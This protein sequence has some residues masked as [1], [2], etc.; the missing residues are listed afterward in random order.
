MNKKITVDVLMLI[1][2]IVEFLSLPIIIHEIVGIGLIFL[3]ALHINY[4][5]RYFKA[6]RKGKYNLKRTFELIVN[7]GLLVS[8]LI[9]IISGIF[10]SQKSFKGKKIGKY[11]IKHIHKSSSIISLVF[12][13]LHLGVT[14]KKLL[15]ELKKGKK[16]PNKKETKIE[17]K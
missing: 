3:I 11:D 15:R 16:K 14:H 1:A 13:A 17:N 4:N 2:I 7:L 9:T 10:T 8:L 12:L 5:K 6:I